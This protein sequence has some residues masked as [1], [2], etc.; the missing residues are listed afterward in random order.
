MK[1][2]ELEN[3]G[4]PR[5]EIMSLAIRL[6]ADASKRGVSKADLRVRVQNVIGAP[7]SNE[8][9]PDFGELARALLSERAK[10]QAASG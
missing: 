2:R 5:G 8:H 10:P 7:A 4:V 6:I 9:D 1:S 3:L